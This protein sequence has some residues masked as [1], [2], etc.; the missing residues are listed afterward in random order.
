MLG[1]LLRSRRRAARANTQAARLARP[2]ISIGNISMGG[3]G[4]TPLV[5][6]IARLL[7][8]AGEKPA[9]L[10]RGYRRAHAADGVT[11]VS[12]GLRTA[13]GAVDLTHLADLSVSGDEPLMLAEAVPGA[14]V[15][16]CEQRALAG[17]VAETSLGCTVHV[18]DDG[19]QHYALKRNIDIVL[20][21]ESDLE[22]RLAPLG[23][24]REPIDALADAHAIIVDGGN[25]FVVERVQAEWG[26]GTF[27]GGMV[28]TMGVPSQS[29][30]PGARVLAVAGIAGPERFFSSVASGWSV[31]ATMPFKDH[32]RF[33]P[34]DVRAMQA[35]AAAE[36]AVAIVV[37]SKDFVKLRRFPAGAVPIVELPLD[38]RVEPAAFGDW[39]LTSLRRD[40][41]RL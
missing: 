26:A 35:R 22:G 41:D 40:D 19:F 36:R 31:V 34:A 4:K 2:V 23:R 15:L 29:L 20:L 3:R 37:T 7:V 39:L 27:V 8:A 11:I 32:H 10:S 33:T 21:A 12:R 16:V 24:L 38:V 5:A 17:A 25:P 28:R 6:H 13:D 1:R 14:A 9:I 30:A 18:L